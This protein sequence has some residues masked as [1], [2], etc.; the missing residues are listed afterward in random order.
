MRHTITQHPDSDVTFEA[1]CLRC[2]WTATPSADSAAVDVQ[3]MSHTGLTGHG[4]FRRIC[5]SF[6]MVVRD[7]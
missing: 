1:E 7:E 4:G 3:C 5:T 6:A 2:D